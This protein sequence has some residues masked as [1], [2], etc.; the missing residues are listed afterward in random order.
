MLKRDLKLRDFSLLISFLNFLLFHFPFFRFVVNNVDYKTFNGVSIIISLIILML[1]ANFF[2]FY[3]ILFLS[4]I[5]GKVLLVLFFIINSIAVYFIN[6]YSVIIDES[7]IGNILNTNYEES[8]SFFSFKL[9]LYL[10]LLGILPGIYIIKAKIIKE[11]PKKFFITSS[12]TL[13]FMIILAFANASNWL[14]IDKNS[15]TLGGLAMPW[16]YSVNI[17]LFYIHQS[18]KNEKE[19]LLPKAT[20]KDNQKS[21]MILVIGESAR[22]QN[23]SLYG[24]GKNT[25]PLLSKI[26]NLHSYKAT[27]CATY[28][29]AGVKCILEHKNTDDL[30]EILPNYLYRNNVDVIWKTT[31]WGEPPV[32]I[33][34]YQN[35]ETL[36]SRC[37]GENCQYDEVLLNG[38]KEEILAS[39]KDKIL[40]VLHT[41]TSHGPTY[42]KKYPPKFEVFKP[43]CNSVELGKC[44][45]EELINAYDNTIVYTD[46]ILSSIIEDLKELKGYNSAMLYVSDHGESLGEKNLYMHGV[47]ISIAPKEQYEIPFIVW[48]SDGSKQLKPNNT[49]S[50]NHVFH[51]VLNFLG[52]QSP[53]YDEKMNIFK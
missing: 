38:L 30:Y 34:N 12:L 24:Y 33:K 22:S 5:G 17:S 51:S 25:N 43:V 19:I 37:K 40:I 36:E 28:T 31:N 49:L 48:T 44:S 32:H 53:A 47:P 10:L 2:T 7:M 6:T 1:A 4:R 14:W 18:K 26:P 21:V 42:S 46:Y 27:S 23:F 13:L 20:I 16:S 50:Q 11:K 9:I 35:K 8:S 15:K 29:T 45:K 52:V 3:L 41:S 39:K